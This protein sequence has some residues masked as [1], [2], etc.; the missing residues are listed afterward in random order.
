MQAFSAISGGDSKGHRNDD[1]IADRMMYKATVFVLIVLTAFAVTHPVIGDN[2]SCWSPAHF[3]KAWEDYTNQYCWA[4]STYALPMDTAIPRGHEVE[5]RNYMSYY[6]WVPYV[7]LALVGSCLLPIGI[8][9]ALNT[10][11]GIDVNNVMECSEKLTQI[12]HTD[13]KTV[14]LYEAFVVTSFQ[15][16]FVFG[17]GRYKFSLT[18]LYAFVKVLFIATIILQMVALSAFLGD[19]FYSY[20]INVIT[21]LT[22]SADWPQLPSFPRVTMCDFNV[23]LMGSVQR[24]TVQCAL[25]LNLYYEKIFFFIWLWLIT[26]LQFQVYRAMVWLTS[27]LSLCRRQAYIASHLKNYDKGILIRSVLLILLDIIIVEE[28]LESGS[29]LN[30]LDCKNYF[31]AYTMFFSLKNPTF[32]WVMEEQLVFVTRF[33]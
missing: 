19:S 1:D 13:T 10:G 16:F 20:G 26:V 17:R 4:R 31:I 23:R 12:L 22:T 5:K 29:G 30:S 21:A 15:R 25:T 18:L 27:L 8:W 32:T 28:F 14:E 9:R 11:Y 2:I 3:K 7:M 24:Y 6:Q 33:V